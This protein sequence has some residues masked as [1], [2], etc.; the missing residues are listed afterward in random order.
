M[1]AIASFRKCTLSNTELLEKI[2][3]QT[4]RIFQIQRVPTRNV[5]AEPNEDYDLL[6]GEMLQRFQE[7]SFW[8]D[9]KK[10]TPQL[11]ENENYSPNVFAVC[12]GQLSVMCYCYIP[13]EDGG[14][15][16]ANCNG[17]IDGD[18][19]FDDNYEVTHWQSFPSLPKLETV[20]V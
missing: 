18:A 10:E 5:P 9:A 8:V 15:V 1:N 2:D 20:A 4:D 6:I 17:K 19:E 12:N 7:K 3:K 13:G 14:Y 16:W 11:L